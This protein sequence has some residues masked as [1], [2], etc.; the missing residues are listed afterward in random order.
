LLALGLGGQSQATAGTMVT[1]FTL[2]GVST[3][4]FSGETQ[5]QYALPT[6]PGKVM[7]LPAGFEGWEC[8]VGPQIVTKNGLVSHQVSCSIGSVVTVLTWI[9]CAATSEDHEGANWALLTGHGGTIV[10]FAECR[11]HLQ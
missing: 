4:T 2:R 7:V 10:F 1:T 5:V 8:K 6:P 9:G 11:T 3:N